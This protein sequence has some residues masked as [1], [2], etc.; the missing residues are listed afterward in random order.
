MLQILS[1][2]VKT[3]T[4]FF[5]VARNFS[6]VCIFQNQQYFGIN[7][8]CWPCASLSGVEWNIFTFTTCCVLETLAGL[9][10]SPQFFSLITNLVTL[11]KL[12][13]WLQRYVSHRSH[14]IVTALQNLI[15][16]LSA[17]TLH[18]FN[19]GMQHDF[20]QHIITCF[21]HICKVRENTNHPSRNMPW[22]FIYMLSRFCGQTVRWD[23][24]CDLIGT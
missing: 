4:S 12:A 13:E 22:N 1:R 19:S 24:S 14:N 10:V 3:V 7:I 8:Y 11:R 23:S 21:V 17:F 5:L 16:R 18:F 15:D 20:L 6:F 9:H 2:N